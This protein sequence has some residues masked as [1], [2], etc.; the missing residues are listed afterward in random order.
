MLFIC[1]SCVF[2]KKPHYYFLSQKE[3]NPTTFFFFLV[4]I[5][6]KEVWDKVGSQSEIC[7]WRLAPDCSPQQEHLS[8][9]QHHTTRQNMS[10]ETYGKCPCFLPFWV[11]CHIQFHSMGHELQ[12]RMSHFKNNT[13]PLSWSMCLLFACYCLT[14][15]WLF[16]ERKYCMIS[17]WLCSS[18]S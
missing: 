10:S 18:R 7:F 6:M 11:L 9:R 12:A 3:R 1:D 15:P 13:C 17:R 8:N 4:D 16:L 14:S 5:Q 2:K